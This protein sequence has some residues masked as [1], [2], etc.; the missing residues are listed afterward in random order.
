MP[1]QAGLRLAQ[2]LGEVGDRQFG[3][4]DQRQ[5]AQPRRFARR[6][7]RAGQGRKAQLGRVHRGLRCLALEDI[8]ISLYA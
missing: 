3:L 2:N 5:N 7:E 1:R 6:L 4:G 8:K